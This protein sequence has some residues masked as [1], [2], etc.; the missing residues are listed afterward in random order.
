M[1]DNTD[2]QMLYL[3]GDTL[4]YVASGVTLPFNPAVHNYMITLPVGTSLFPDLS[5]EQDDEWQTVSR[6]TISETAERKI[7]QVYVTAATGKQSVYTVNFEIEQSDNTLLSQIYVNDRLLSD[8]DPTQ[9][10][11]PK[12]DYEAGDA[13]QII[14]MDT[15][16]DHLQGQKSM[17][18]KVE[19]TVTAQNHANR[20]Y[21]IH[22]PMMLSG[23]SL[24]SMIWKNGQPMSDFNKEVFNYTIDVPYDESGDRVMPAITV[25]KMEEEQKVDIT[26]EGDSAIV[27][28]V[29]A[30]DGIHTETY[31]IDFM[32]GLS[33]V[34][35]LMDIVV[36]GESLSE[37][38]PR[39]STYTL[40]FFAAD[41]LPEVDWIKADPMQTL[42][43]STFD[44][45]DADGHRIVT[46]DCSVTA[47]DG[48]HYADY[49]LYFS[50]SK[51]AADTVALSAQ[52]DSLFVRG[53]PVSRL[54]GF[55]KDFHAD[56]LSY[57]MK[58]YPIGSSAALFFDTIDIS[59]L[60][61]DPFALHWYETESRYTEDEQEVERTIYLYVSDH[62][63]Q[64]TNRYILQQRID[65]SH[66]STVT[67]ILLD[68]EPMLEFDPEVHE[69]QIYVN[70]RVPGITYHVNDSLAYAPDV[71]PG[72]VTTDTTTQVK[73]YTITCMSQYAYIY[74]KTNPSLRNTYTIEFIQSDLNQT[75]RPEANDIL[76]K[77]IPGSTQVAFA[78]LRNDVQVAIFDMD[79]HFLF[80]R[81]LPAIDPRYAV[82]S[83]DANGKDYFNDVTD[84]SKCFV[85][86]L[87]ARMLYMYTI[88]SGNKRIVRSG[89]L[90]FR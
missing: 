47:P 30:E 60:A 88:F 79:G 6:Q 52:L 32:Y 55:D 40:Y 41:T 27:I 31:R 1:S 59:F 70:G 50:F 37:F 66:D 61:R 22:F 53:L 67:A 9:T 44:N 77:I 38:D 26:A 4:T 56:S 5:W 85:M 35:D 24:L 58:A 13:Y 28:K 51:T 81:D 15:L 87:D 11:L 20:V 89:K 16:V 73:P 18:K 75:A 21:T 45:T 8:F 82:V 63:G 72:V 84:L 3:D 74:D 34:T 10:V 17:E 43:V 83:K 7:E 78:S 64:T 14:R 39:T 2:L 42:D 86:T 71:T 29:L 19:I 23:E 46:L 36:A 62:E 69:Y 76:V 33:P 65:L 57:Q 80:F 25:T 68:G 90:M 12:V 48:E 54:N 49:V